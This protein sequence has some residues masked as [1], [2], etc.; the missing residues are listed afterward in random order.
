MNHDD[1]NQVS[2]KVK[3]EITPLQNTCVNSLL[4]F[5]GVVQITLFTCWI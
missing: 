1:I 5:D 4:N 3:S 2:W